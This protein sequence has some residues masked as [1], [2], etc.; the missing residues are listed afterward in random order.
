MGIDEIE[1]TARNRASMS[2]L[3]LVDSPPSAKAQ[4][5]AAMPRPH[6]S[7]GASQHRWNVAATAIGNR[8]LYLFWLSRTSDP[9]RVGVA[10][11]RFFADG[12]IALVSVTGPTLRLVP[13]KIRVPL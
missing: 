7:G 12:G 8:P 10:L 13:T 6:R 11:S 9:E 2:A 1:T 5:A 3:R 4:E